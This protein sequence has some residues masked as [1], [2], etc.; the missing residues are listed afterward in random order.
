MR[1]ARLGAETTISIKLTQL[2]LGISAEVCK[3]NVDPLVAKAKELGTSVEIDMEQSD[4]VDGTLEVVGLMHARY[5]AV[6]A[7]V[8]AYLRSTERDI[9]CLNRHR[10]PIR[11]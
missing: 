11:L 1:V 5:G 2:G 10:I 4:Y 8:Q 9:E 3:E 7:V 6:R